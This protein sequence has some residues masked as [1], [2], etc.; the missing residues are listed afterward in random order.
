VDRRELG[1]VVRQLQEELDFCASNKFVKAE[2]KRDRP[3][4]RQNDA[5]KQRQQSAEAFQVHQQKARAH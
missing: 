2:V 3:N 1:H 5:D 4:P